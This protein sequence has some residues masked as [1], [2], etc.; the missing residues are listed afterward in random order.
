MVVTVEPGI[1]IPEKL[2]IRIE[3]TYLVTKDG[4]EALTL[5]QQKLLVFAKK[6]TR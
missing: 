6:N 2:G 5:S 1:Y 3:D 4:P